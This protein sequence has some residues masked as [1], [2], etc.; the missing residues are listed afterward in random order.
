[1]TNL[2]LVD[3][4]LRP[5]LDLWPTMDLD[6]AVLATI[7]SAENRMPTPPIVP[8]DVQLT[9][10]RVADQPAHPTS[11]CLCIRRRGKR[12][13]PASTISMVAAMYWAMRLA[14]NSRIGRWRRTWIASSCR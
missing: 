4:E 14:W 9:R 11:S 12:R 6:P 13:F 1:M 2:A 10:H 5:L 3:P 8:N 7:R